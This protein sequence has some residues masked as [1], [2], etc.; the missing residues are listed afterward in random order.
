MQSLTCKCPKIFEWKELGVSLLVLIA[1]PA[2]A[3]PV[4]ASPLAWHTLQRGPTQPAPEQAALI[5][6]CLR[7]K[8]FPSPLEYQQPASLAAGWG[9]RHTARWAGSPRGVQVEAG[10]ASYQLHWLMQLLWPQ[11]LLKR[12]PGWTVTKKAGPGWGVHKGEMPKAAQ[13]SLFPFIPHWQG[14]LQR[15]QWYF[16]IQ[17]LLVCSFQTSEFYTQW[18]LEWASILPTLTRE[19]QTGGELCST[20]NSFPA[21][22][23]HLAWPTQQRKLP[24]SSWNPGC[25][26]GKSDIIHVVANKFSNKIFLTRKILEKN[27]REAGNR[28]HLRT[29]ALLPISSR[30]EEN[31]F[32]FTA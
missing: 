20:S 18:F 16:A 32:A 14:F 19:G 31:T 25:G 27:A 22:F 12:G 5:D 3:Q 30:P 13:T 29:S 2:P 11:N 23:Q 15:C 28:S 7:D 21:R 10:D 26:L 8:C 4:M 17:P 6:S 1:G 9:S 24:G